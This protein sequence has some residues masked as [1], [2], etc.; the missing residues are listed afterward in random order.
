MSEDTES[1]ETTIETTEGGAAETG[2]NSAES[3][4][5]QEGDGLF[6][7]KTP[8]QLY[9]SYKELQTTYQEGKD[10]TADLEGRF[11]QY[12]GIDKLL[13]TANFLSSNPRFQ[14]WMDTEKNFQATGSES[15]EAISPDQQ[16]AMDTVRNIAQQVF[17]EAFDS[18]VSPIAQ[19]VNSDQL[20]RN[21][22][23]MKDKYPDFME[24]KQEMSELASG[25]PQEVQDNPSVKQLDNLY[26]EALRQNPAKWEAK[27]RDIYEKN[28]AEKKSQSTEKP[29]GSQ[30]TGSGTGD[31][32]SWTEALAMAKKTLSGG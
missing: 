15:T 5:T 8:E 29:S 30:T 7:G 1:T 10:S 22:A 3:T 23:S 17:Q 25:W 2:D 26:W 16:K 12:G 28:L 4:G 14:T 19:S 11:S 18:K 24:F 32:S 20:E 9:D 21:M 13:E 6:D 31:A 27:M